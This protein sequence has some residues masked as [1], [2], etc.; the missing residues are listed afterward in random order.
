MRRMV[1]LLLDVSARETTVLNVYTV[2]REYEV[3]SWD[4]ARSSAN[5]QWPTLIL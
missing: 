3:G 1:L 5:T 2:Y 4:A